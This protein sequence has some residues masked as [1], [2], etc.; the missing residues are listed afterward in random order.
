MF[1][2]PPPSLPARPPF[3]QRGTSQPLLPAS[4]ED[5]SSISASFFFPLSWP[6]SMAT[7]RLKDE[8]EWGSEAGVRPRGG[9]VCPWRHPLCSRIGRLWLLPFRAAGHCR[10]ISRTARVSDS[11]APPLPPP[12]F[13]FSLPLFRP[14]SRLSLRMLSLILACLGMLFC[15]AFWKGRGAWQRFT[16]RRWCREVHSFLCQNTDYAEIY[17]SGLLWTRLVLWRMLRR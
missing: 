16:W 15:P 14:G 6:V 10:F 9:G 7:V 1:L 13:S 8:R 4:L 2:A 11:C 5:I 12:W 17:R 3:S